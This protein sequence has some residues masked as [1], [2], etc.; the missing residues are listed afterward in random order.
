MTA[1]ATLID[2]HG[3]DYYL[4]PDPGYRR[5]A[6]VIGLCDGSCG[7]RD[8]GEFFVD[9]HVIQEQRKKR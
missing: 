3:T 2:D 4:F 9:K 5:H 7:N 1:T 8:L 6:E